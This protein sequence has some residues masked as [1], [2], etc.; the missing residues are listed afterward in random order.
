MD[1]CVVRRVGFDLNIEN[2]IYILQI[3]I[4]V[5]KHIDF[6]FQNI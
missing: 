4:L 5:A 1:V 2:E 6:F 3:Y